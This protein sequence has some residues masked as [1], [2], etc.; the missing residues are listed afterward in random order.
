[1]PDELTEAGRVLSAENQGA[2]VAAF[3]SLRGV[4]KKAMGVDP[5]DDSADAMPADNTPPAKE[6]ADELHLTSDLVPLVEASKR[7]D[8]TVPLKIIDAG[9]GSSGYYSAD[10]LKRDGPKV[11]TSGLHMY[12]DHPSVTEEADRP[13][14]SVKDLAGER[15]TSGAARAAE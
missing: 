12:L 6:S 3:R 15:G 1:M 11:F 14:R 10:V 13:E 9:W 5:I 2:L 8:G 7:K 4:L